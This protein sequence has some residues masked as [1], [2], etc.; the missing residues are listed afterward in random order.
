MKKMMGILL[1]LVF[2][3]SLICAAT[4]EDVVPQPEGGK[5]FES[6]WA[7]MNGLI[8]IYY[9]EEGYRVMVDLFNQ[10]DNTGTIWE[11]S[12]YYVEER[13]DLESIS[14]RKIGYT[15]DPDTLE[16]TLGEYEYE[17]IDELENTSVFTLSEDG[18][19]SWKDGHEN[20]GQ[21][22]E[23]REIGQ[24]DGVWRN[25]SEDVYT[26]FHWQ[27]LYDENTYF[28][29]AFVAR[30][31][32]NYQIA[33]MYDA[34]TGRLVCYDSEAA[35]I[36][37]TE[38]FLTAEEAGRPYDIVFTDLGS[39]KMLFETADGTKLELEY[40]ILGPES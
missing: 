23:F 12:C 36:E 34:E 8:E 38:G 18:A 39:G 22:L 32:D 40:D 16:K 31:E 29:Y 21:D 6:N 2:A 26:E 28:Y 27:G 24:F 3:L 30:G 20:I 25:D 13:D 17:G 4:A 14:S 15:F 1:A 19:L 35:G 5:K 10:V 9:E 7:M 11:Y 33:G 37:D